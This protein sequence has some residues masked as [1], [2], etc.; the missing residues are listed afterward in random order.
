MDRL[1]QQRGADAIEDVAWLRTMGN[2]VVL[3][4]SDPGETEPAIRGPES[5]LEPQRDRCG[6]PR[7]AIATRTEPI[8]KA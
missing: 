6:H 1:A 3:A 5:A 8:D 7:I 4:P 2:I